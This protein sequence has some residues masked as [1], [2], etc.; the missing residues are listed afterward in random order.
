MLC[1]KTKKKKE[2]IKKKKE[3]KKKRALSVSFFPSFIVHPPKLFLFFFFGVL[4][5]HYSNAQWL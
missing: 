5:F 2:K 4:T 1:T 3:K